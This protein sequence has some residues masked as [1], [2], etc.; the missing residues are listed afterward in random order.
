[1]RIG[2]VRTS[3]EKGS[4]EY[5]LEAIGKCD[6]VFTDIISGIKSSRPALDELLS[7][8]RADDTVVVHSIS[9][10]GRNLRIV[11]EIVEKFNLRGV[12]LISIKEG[13][14]ASTP[15]GR[16]VM[17]ILASVA[18]LEREQ[19]VERMQEGRKVSKKKQGRKPLLPSKKEA[20]EAMLK[21]GEM[22]HT[23][24]MKSV[25]LS[26]ASFYKLLKQIETC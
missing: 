1:M 24:I 6:R 12:K 19:I 16:L 11:L 8:A 2:Y 10:L 9:R 7:F 14:D 17:N 21:T 18:E 3:T 23:A 13:F 4:Q 5:Q 25:G 15:T 20:V 22:T 26:R